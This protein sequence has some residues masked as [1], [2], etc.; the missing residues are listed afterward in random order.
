[1]KA[2]REDGNV[3]WDWKLIDVAVNNALVRSDFEVGDDNR[4]QAAF[5]LA[6]H[7]HLLQVVRTRQYL[8]V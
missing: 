2:R 6:L 1:M 8:F 7:L 5:A 4:I 3:E